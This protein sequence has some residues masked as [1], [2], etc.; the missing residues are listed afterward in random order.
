[1]EEEIKKEE[2]Q[3][4]KEEEQGEKEKPLDKMTVKDL[5][6]IAVEIPDLT[7]VHAMKKDELL[8]V[9]NEARGIKEEAPI[10]KSKEKVSKKKV[11][12]QE[13]SVKELKQKVVR[14]KEEKGTARKAKDRK[15][16]DLLRRRINRL[17]KQTRKLAQ[18]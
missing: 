1:M 14:F 15:R 16:V 10:E 7:G 6:E 2:G 11:S 13:V 3:E 8:K 4:V 17:K 18:A 5:R 9:I 12:K